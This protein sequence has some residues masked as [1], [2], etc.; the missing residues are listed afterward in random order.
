MKKALFVTYG[1]GHIAMVLPVIRALKILNPH[2]E[3]IL[4][5][6]TTGAARARAAGLECLGYADFLHHVDANAALAI[7][8]K[9]HENN[10]SPDVST[11]ESHA[12]LGINYLD[13]EEQH[14]VFDAKVIYE[15]KGRYAFLPLNF[16]R[17]VLA[18]ISPD[19]VV[20]TN[21][22]RSEEAALYAAKE[23]V[24]PCMAMV[25]LFGLVSDTFVTRT[26]K[27]DL[28]CVLSSTVERSLVDNG[29]EASSLVVTGNPAF[30]GLVSSDVQKKADLFLTRLGWHGRRVILYIGA[31]ESV[32]HTGT[33]VPAGR[34]FPMEIEKI[35]KQYVASQPNTAL[36]IRYHPSDWS[37]YPRLAD[38]D[39]VYFSEPPQEHIHP[40]ILASCV[41][42]NTNSTVGLEAVV[43]GKAVISI[44][45]SPSV[46]H[47][48]SLAQLGIS[49]P[50]P[51]HFDL[52]KTLDD[53]LSH[54]RPRGQFQSGGKAAFRVAAQIS[55]ILEK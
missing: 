14:G 7:G 49:Y 15:A 34:S 8:A 43:A 16:M 38:T 46:H 35:L 42:V 29:F 41:I 31:W 39:R 21:S 13:L 5:A 45:N 30:D 28:T 2:I 53:V 3:C 37:V 9:L 54:K 20:T 6:L 55:K 4:L 52:P 11:H 10:N 32:A 51:T 44:E 27:P 18:E 24:I 17:R 23:L 40:L 19:I 48:F 33:S 50:S 26:T 1:G 12:Y 47:W 25:D 22:P 36:I